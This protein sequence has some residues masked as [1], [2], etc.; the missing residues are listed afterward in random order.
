[1]EHELL[2]RFYKQA[3]HPYSQKETTLNLLV[4]IAAKGTKQPDPP[5]HQQ[6]IGHIHK[7][8]TIKTKVRA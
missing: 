7:A 1:M 6:H 4:G 8:S 2:L 5:K 3:C